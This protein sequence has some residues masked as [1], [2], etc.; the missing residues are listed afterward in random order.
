M[1][2]LSR[3][4]SAAHLLLDLTALSVK[5]QDNSWSNID[6]EWYE[7][8]DFQI[9]AEIQKCFDSARSLLYKTSCALQK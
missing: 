7:S 1:A 4:A 8:S 6:A 3:D 9:V 5:E 2:T